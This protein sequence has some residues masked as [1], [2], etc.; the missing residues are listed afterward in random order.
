MVATKNIRV[1]VKI[2]PIS[3]EQHRSAAVFLRR[4]FCYS[5]KSSDSPQV[6][7]TNGGIRVIHKSE[8]PSHNKVTYPR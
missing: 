1:K 6:K 8:V 3:E 7:T 5:S 4:L 2:Q